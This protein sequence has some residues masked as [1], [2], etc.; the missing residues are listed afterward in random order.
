MLACVYQLLKLDLLEISTLVP[1]SLR[2][3]YYQMFNADN[4]DISCSICMCHENLSS[5][6][7]N[8]F[9]HTIFVLM[10]ILQPNTLLV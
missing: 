6:F 3:A 4:D 9:I 10:N 7:P 5:G 1:L 8:V 2:A